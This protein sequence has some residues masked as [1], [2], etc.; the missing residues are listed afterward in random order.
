MNYNISWV[1]E[2]ALIN[3]LSG[4]QM[5]FLGTHKKKGGP[6]L[7]QVRETNFD[8]Q[9]LVLIIVIEP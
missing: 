7:P 9:N 1:R 5:I 3:I 6:A 8:N 4:V 2:I